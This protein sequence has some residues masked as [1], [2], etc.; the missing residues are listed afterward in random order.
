MIFLMPNSIQLRK[1]LGKC[2]SSDKIKI[3]NAFRYF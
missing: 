1:I 3:Y 2:E